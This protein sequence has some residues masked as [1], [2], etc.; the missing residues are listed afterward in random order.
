MITF[1]M[2]LIIGLFNQN[3]YSPN[4]KAFKGF[5]VWLSVE[6]YS[7]ALHFH[8]LRNYTLLT[9]LILH[10]GSWP[11]G[12]G[13]ATTISRSGFR[14]WFFG[15]GDALCCRAKRF[16]YHCSFLVSCK[17]VTLRRTGILSKKNVL[18]PVICTP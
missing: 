13:N 12:H 14:L 4:K 6:Q 8:N 9:F 11:S 5:L 7:S 15:P 2:P 3:W 18:I 17:W 10:E 16:I 1:R